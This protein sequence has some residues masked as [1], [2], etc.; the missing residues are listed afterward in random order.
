MHRKLKTAFSILC[1]IFFSAS[2][3]F[4]SY[5]L[6]LETQVP[7]PM[8]QYD[9]EDIQSLVV[10]MAIPEEEKAPTI[11]YNAEELLATNEDFTGWLYIPDSYINLPVV[12]G[13][14]NSWYL[15][16]SF[17][18][19]YSVFGCP[20][21]D[22]NTPSGSRNRV[23]HGHNMGSKRT[24]M[25]SRLLDYQDQA[26]AEE[27]KYIYYSEPG[28]EGETYEVFAVLNFDIS[29]L[30]TFNCYKPDFDT[31]D[32]FND[33][34]SYLKTKSLYKT[35]YV[36][37]TETLILSTCNRYYGESNRLLICAGKTSQQITE[38]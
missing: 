15:T 10:T 31:E 29:N 16:H 34:I 8:D 28:T 6:Y 9:Y 24:E 32:D 22:I 25:F 4:Y 18:K 27:H 14:D 38:Q 12:T 30:D 21:I 17:T 5:Y 7:D 35:D 1:L 11:Q 26:Y 37:N 13:T 19:A 20:F 23:I 2:V 36:P 3:C 33:F